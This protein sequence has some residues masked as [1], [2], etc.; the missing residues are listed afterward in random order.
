MSQEH[1]FRVWDNNRKIYVEPS[2][3]TILGTG[4]WTVYD[5]LNET[6]AFNGDTIGSDLILERFTGLLVK[7]K[8]L[9]AMDIVGGHPHGT[10]IVKWNDD[11]ASYAAYDA[12]GN[13][14]GLFANELED[15][16]DT[17]EIIGNWRENPELLKGE[18]Q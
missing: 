11:F 5:D 14:Y 17:W 18:S 3:I 12:E 15:C 1:K 10:V 2:Y 8:E 4:K 16:K 9:Y 7:G 6:V 13:D